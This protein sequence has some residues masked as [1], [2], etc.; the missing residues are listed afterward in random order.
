MLAR[1]SGV[2]LAI[3]PSAIV[4][5]VAGVGFRV[6]V[7]T[8]VI[9]E[10]GG[11]GDAVILHTHLY[12]REGEM[13]LYGALDEPAL[14]LFR[15][16]I[17]VN[18]VGPKA[19]LALLSALAAPALRAAIVAEDVDALT[20]AHGIGRKTAQRVVLDLRTKLEGEGL[21][22]LAAGAATGFSVSGADLDAIAALTGLGYSA[23]EARRALASSLSDPDAPIEERIRAALRALGGA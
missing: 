7:P 19:A 18:G 22:A 12:V 11:V 20:A 3:E 13:T 23:A 15:D 9:G 8:T 16:L 4:V 14:D 17:A 10:A 1:L 21:A 6:H 5:D 2:I